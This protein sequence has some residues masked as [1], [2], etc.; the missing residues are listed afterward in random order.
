MFCRPGLQVTLA[1]T[2]T[3]LGASREKI[4]VDWKDAKR[5]FRAVM[6]DLSNDK[7]PTQIIKGFI[8]LTVVN[9]NAYWVHDI[10]A[11]H[12]KLVF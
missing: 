6:K 7:F 8:Q 5:N 10:I 4:N 1:S 11:Q 12:V 9:D 3:T 2:Q